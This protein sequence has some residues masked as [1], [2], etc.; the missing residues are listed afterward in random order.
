MIKKVTIGM[1]IGL[2]LGVIAAMLMASRGNS[3]K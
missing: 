2:L 3:K 1:I